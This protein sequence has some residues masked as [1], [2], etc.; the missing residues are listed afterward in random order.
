[1]DKVPGI[2]ETRWMDAAITLA[3][4][5][6]GTVVGLT[7]MGG[8]A[9][10]TPVLV[11]FFGVPPLAAVSS[12]LAASAVMKPFGGLVHAQ[13]GTVRWRIVGWLCVGS[14]PGAFSGVLLLRTLGRADAV[15]QVVQRALGVALLLAVA[16]LLTKAYLAATRRDRPGGGPVRVRPLPTALLGALGGLV[17]GMTSV[18]S[19]SMII[20][21]LLLVYPALRTN[22]VV[23]TDLVQAIPL[24]G[25]AALGHALFGDLRLDLTAALLAGSIPGVLLGALVSARAPTGLVRSALAVVLLASSLKLLGAP[26]LAVPFAVGSLAAGALLLTRLPRTVAARRVAVVAGVRAGAFEDRAVERGP[27]GGFGDRGVQDSRPCVTAMT[28]AHPCPRSSSR[29]ASTAASNSPPPTGPGSVR[30]MRT[31]ARCREPE[32]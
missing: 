22:D 5:G 31:P 4:F 28:P 23:G 12:D 25:A 13:R 8:G 19:G 3:G 32:W 21:T 20:V 14:V 17:V 16:G 30:T 9:L 7:G 26:N 24:V 1:M 18:G 11:L 29:S 15:Q 2:T 6:V 27:G 10:M